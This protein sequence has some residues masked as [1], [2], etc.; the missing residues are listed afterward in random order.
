MRREEE[1]KLTY[2]YRDEQIAKG[3]KPRLLADFIKRTGRFPGESLTE[4]LAR[5]PESWDRDA[6][7]EEVQAESPK[8][9]KSKKESA[10]MAAER[11]RNRARARSVPAEAARLGGSYE[12]EEPLPVVPTGRGFHCVVPV[13]IGGLRFR[14][15]LDTGCARSF[16]RKSFFEQ[17]SKNSKTRSSI[18]G[19]F[20]GDEGLSCVGIKKDMV[21]DTSVVFRDVMLEF[22]DTP[23]DGRKPGLPFTTRT[24]FVELEDAADCLLI[25]Y[26]ELI[27]EFKPA[28]DQDSDGYPWVEFRKA[29]IMLVGERIGPT[30]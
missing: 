2:E 27:G 6:V 9:K 13:W 30:L 21:A 23:D 8:R 20:R 18:V 29:G 7:E 10:K 17:L 22:R 25:G 11:G 16:I 5:Q 1:R 19:R 26:P 15:T 3:A 4:Y 14:I 24:R 28:F 12:Y